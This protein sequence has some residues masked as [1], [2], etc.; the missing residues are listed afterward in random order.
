MAKTNPYDSSRSTE[1]QIEQLPGKPHRT[2][3]KSLMMVVVT[4]LMAIYLVNPTA[5]V[6][7]FIPDNFP[8]IGNLDEATA[9]AI[10]LG[11]LSYFGIHLPWM[12]SRD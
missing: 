2:P 12:H 4:V 11:S 5:G 1:P 9:T 6:F 7:E 3:L 10:L 8:I